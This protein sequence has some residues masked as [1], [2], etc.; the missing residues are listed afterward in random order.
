MK[1]LKIKISKKT[2]IIG[3][4]G[5]CLSALYTCESFV[6]IDPPNNQLTGDIV[7]EDG[8]TVDAALVYVYA[9]LRDNVLTSG[10]IIGIPYHM[11]LYTDELILYN[12]GLTQQQFFTNNLTPSNNVIGSAWNN[13]YNLIFATNSIIEGIQNSDSLSETDSNIFLGEAYFLRAYIHFYLVNLYGEIPYIKTT[14]YDDNANASKLA[15][16][17]VYQMLEE[18]LLLCQS[19]FMESDTVTN[20][21]RPNKWIAK[22]LLSRVYLYNEEWESALNE[23]NTIILSGNYSLNPDLNSVFLKNSTETIW[24]YDAGQPGANTND[25]GGYIFNSGPP[26]NSSLTIDLINSFETDD[27]RFDSWVGSVSDD[28][29]TW[30]YPFKYKLN[31]VTAET[32]ECSIVFRLAEIYLIAAEAN[33]KLGNIP[34]ALSSVNLI[35][36]RA[37]LSPL[38]NT[39]SEIVLDQIIQEKRIEFF[40]EMSHRFFDLK[41]TD[42]IDNV[43]SSKKPNWQPTDKLLPLPQ[44][45]LILN[46]NLLPQNNGY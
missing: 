36:S 11:G 29:E 33:A 17:D 16:N 13:A 25:A 5:L 46:S 45:E 31:T 24:Q 41:R 9:Q 27:M 18:D 23:A 3:L 15:V 32:Q 21:F 4:C 8:S 42:K 22:A 19:Y 2:F 43:L 7:F 37:S 12:P 30:Y 20:N 10:S 14:Q 26:P 39:D 6:D 34:E 38:T 40:T 35:R 28:T 1:T 44:S